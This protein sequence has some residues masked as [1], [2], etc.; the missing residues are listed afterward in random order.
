MGYRLFIALD[1]SE[2][3]R[4]RVHAAATGLPW[5]GPPG[6]PAG[7]SKINFVAADNIH[8]TLHFLGE[9]AD[10]RLMDVHRAVEAAAGQVGPFELAVTGLRAVPAQGRLRMI[11][12]GVAEPTGRLARL[13]ELLGVG[14]HE[15][16]FPTD[17]RRFNPHITLA[18][19]RA[20]READAIRQAVAADEDR[21]FGTCQTDEIVVYSSK[22]TKKGP[23][24]EAMGR[25]GLT[26]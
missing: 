11:W 19:V 24:Y 2:V 4:R 22:L 26:G 17:H 1:V 6:A 13:H 21:L 5:A 12:A 18:R 14:L 3:V 10:D 15:A 20:T 8:L 7:D 23:V 9:V 16:D 25:T